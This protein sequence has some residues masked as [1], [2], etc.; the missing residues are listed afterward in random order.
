MSAPPPFLSL[1]TS[2]EA[3][4]RAAVRGDSWN[5]AG[6]PAEQ[7]EGV[8]Y[9]LPEK[10]DGCNHL[11]FAPEVTVTPDAS[12]ASSPAGLNVN[13]HVPQ[14]AA[15][16]RED[17]AESSMKDITIALPAGVAL[18]PA[19]ADGLQACSESQVGFE[20]FKELD[21]EAETGALTA[22]FSPTLPEPLQQGVSF[23]PNAAKIGTVKL[24]TP[25]LAG[26]LE[27]SVYLAAQ[28]ANPFGS[29]VP[30]SCSKRL[31]RAACS[32]RLTGRRA[33]AEGPAR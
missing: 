24:K 28:S 10:L 25:L 4:F 17:L 8:T 23:C 11:P 7:F 27:G 31:I 2:C 19:G 32:K 9:P 6:H 30:R 1:P 20:G 21:G 13:V 33:G 29:L 14:A 3:P 16:G 5:S 26:P 18:N 22:I 12:A 15:L